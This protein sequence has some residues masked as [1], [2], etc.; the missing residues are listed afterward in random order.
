MTAV[1]CQMLSEEAS[2]FCCA[3]GTNVRLRSAVC[4]CPVVPRYCAPIVEHM[5]CSR[6]REQVAVR[7]SL[8]FYQ[9][10]GSGCTVEAAFSCSQAQL[11]QGNISPL[12]Y[13]FIRQGLFVL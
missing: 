11:R 13:S 7:F 3:I 2:K 5:D 6:A 9:F 10:L 8:E 1:C 4:A 12:Q